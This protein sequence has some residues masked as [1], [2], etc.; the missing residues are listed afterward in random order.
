[1]SSGRPSPAKGA[2]AAGLRGARVGRRQGRGGDVPASALDL[3]FHF[4]QDLQEERRALKK[5]QKMHRSKAMK[6]LMET[7]RRRRAF[8]ERQKEEEAKEQRFREKVLQE[9]KIKFQEATAKF[10]HAHQSFSQQK[11]TG[12]S[13]NCYSEYKLLFFHSWVRGVKR[14]VTRIV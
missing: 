5:D 13:I 8:E 6:Y 4:E 11:Q 2:G 14:P 7:N 12:L 9:R 3:M 10:Q 1:R